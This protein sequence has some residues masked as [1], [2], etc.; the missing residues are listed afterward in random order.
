MAR[1]VVDGAKPAPSI[2]EVLA[3]ACDLT[4]ASLVS[5]IKVSLPSP[6]L[7]A[8]G[9]TMQVGHAEAPRS[10]A[11]DLSEALV[12]MTQFA[13][14]DA[15]CA[16]AALLPALAAARRARSPVRLARAQAL[17]A[18]L[19]KLVSASGSTDG[20]RD[21]LPTAALLLP[22]LRAD[23]Q[24]STR[25]LDRLFALC[26]RWVTSAPPF[27][28]LAALELLAG[29]VSPCCSADIPAARDSCASL[30]ALSGI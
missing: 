17:L 13:V 7:H 24:G 6:P 5:A 19:R 2:R 9:V 26:C 3:T 27:E 4:P 22:A 28:P 16:Q 25:V 30:R 11:I 29:I 12:S 23:Q 10:A 15:D 20:S 21:A 1:R 8:V 14:E 18:L